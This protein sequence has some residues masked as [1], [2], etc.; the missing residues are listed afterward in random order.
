MLNEDKKLVHLV[1][2]GGNTNPL[3]SRNKNYK[4]WCFTW[5]NYTEEDWCKIIKKF[6]QLNIKFICGKEIGKENKIQHIQG[7]AE[8]SSRKRLTTLKNEYSPKIHWEPARGNKLQNINYCNKEHNYISSFPK[9]IKEQAMAI[10][11][12]IVW[13]GWQQQVLEIL[14][15]DP[16]P[17]RIFWYWEEQGNVGKSFIYKYIAGTYECIMGQGKRNDI[18]NQLLTHCT[19][20]P[21]TPPRVI[22]YDIPRSDIDKVNFGTMEAIKNGCVYSGK[23]EGGQMIFPYPHVIVFANTTPPVGVMSDDRFYVSKIHF[24]Y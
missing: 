8:F 23:Y 6:Q 17:R 10:Y 22:I 12:D 20:K 14:N 7:Y 4:R 3:L 16:D 1:Q 19:N 9:T 18:Y 13:R 24:N 11:K 5:N 21:F 2:G 15:M